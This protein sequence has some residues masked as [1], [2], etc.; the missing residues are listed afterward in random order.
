[1]TKQPDNNPLGHLW[2]YMA[3]VHNVLL[4]HTEEGDIICAVLEDIM[5][6]IAGKSEEEIRERY[7]MN[8]KQDAQ[9]TDTVAEQ[10]T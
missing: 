4:T 6:N 9:R 8:K 10:S 5:P 3:D 7:G 1:M 2:Q